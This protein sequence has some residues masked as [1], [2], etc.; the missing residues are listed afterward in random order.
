[1]IQGQSNI[2]E[3][4]QYDAKIIRRTT[5]SCFRKQHKNII[6]HKWISTIGRL[7]EKHTTHWLC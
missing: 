3:V 6:N 4:L 1:M 2:P 7:P 5:L